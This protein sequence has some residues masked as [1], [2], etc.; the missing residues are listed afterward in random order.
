MRRPAVTFN[1]DYEPLL[2]SAGLADYDSVMGTGQGT[3]LPKPGLGSRERIRLQLETPAGKTQT[4]YLKRYG[5]NRPAER[6]WHAVRAVQEAGAPTMEPVG[7]GT[8]S[9]GG[10][11]IVTAVPGEALSRCMDNL[12][13]RRGADTDAMG[14]LAAKLGRLAGTLH[15]AGLAHRD[16]YT[17][18]IFLA[19]PDGEMTLHLID[20][21][22]VFAPR[23]RRWRWWMK[24]LAQLKFSLPTEWAKEY[25][26]HVR[27]AYVAARSTQPP[28]WLDVVVGLRV[29]RMRWRAGARRTR[30]RR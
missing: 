30:T 6:E 3:P 29:W 20:L 25:W 8:G 15:E 5:A 27:A 26:P 19:D 14:E 9:A 7:M 10:F 12:L 17:T 4:V 28:R 23:W 18:H 11:V 13:V 21:A 2:R 22:R 24:D 1:P 16:F